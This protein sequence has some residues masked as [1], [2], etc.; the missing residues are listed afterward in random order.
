[1]IKESQDEISAY[2]YN[3]SILKMNILHA[4]VSTYL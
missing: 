2:N 3:V 4:D 1:M